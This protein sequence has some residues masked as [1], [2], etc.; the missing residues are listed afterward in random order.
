MRKLDVSELAH[1]ARLLPVDLLQALFA[2][3]IPSDPLFDGMTLGHPDVGPIPKLTISVN[4]FGANSALASF[5]QW[6]SLFF[7]GP[8]ALKH[9]QGT[10]RI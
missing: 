5:V 2:R 1:A 10:R 7:D 3:N 9:F 6:T 8:L 4:G